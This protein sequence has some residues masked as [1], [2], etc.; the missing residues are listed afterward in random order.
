MIVSVDIGN[1]GGWTRIDAQCRVVEVGRLPRTDSGPDDEGVHDLVTHW[2]EA[3]VEVVYFERAPGN[4]RIHGRSNPD[5]L[6]SLALWEGIIRGACAKRLRCVGV[7]PRTWKA[8][9]LGRSA[10][11]FGSDEKARAIAYCRSRWPDADRWLVPPGCRVPQDGIA[12]AAAI[13]AYA[14]TCERVAVVTGASS[15]PPRHAACPAHRR[16]RSTRG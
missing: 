4:V 14:W 12:D 5:A 7:E 6:R 10:A 13:G 11:S 1:K 2:L 9:T 8:A 3:G 16:R 15:S